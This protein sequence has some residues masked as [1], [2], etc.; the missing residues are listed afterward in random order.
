MRQY[1]AII[2]LFAFGFQVVKPAGPVGSYDG[3][4]K[5]A[6]QDSLALVAFYY[7]TGGPN[8]R[9]TTDNAFSISNLA[10]GDDYGAAY[11]QGGYGWDWYPNAG[12]GKWL[13]G[14]VKDWFGVLL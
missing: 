2:I 12:T 10:G 13:E 11:Y 7:A 5:C 3:Y 9:R 6:E 8:W 14:P 4:T 1:L